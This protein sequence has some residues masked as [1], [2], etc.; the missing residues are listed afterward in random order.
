MEI[1][2]A[3][4]EDADV[5]SEL[6]MDVQQ[7]HAEALPERFKPPDGPGF[8][9]DFMRERLAQPEAIFFVAAIEGVDAGYVYARRVD[10]PDNPFTFAYKGVYIDQISVKPAFRGR[11]CGA[12]LITAVVEMAR[13]W[14]ASEV[15]LDTHLFNENARVFFASQGFATNILRMAREDLA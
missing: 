7:L 12:A 9:R 5:L 11:G 8:A 3:G 14:G 15:T 2:Q 6:C 1:R 4:P 10:R 13:T